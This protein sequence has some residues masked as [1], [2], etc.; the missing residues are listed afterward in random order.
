M[1]LLKVSFVFFSVIRASV[2][3]L[4]LDYV[5]SASSSHHRCFST[6]SNHHRSFS[7]SSSLHRSFSDATDPSPEPPEAKINWEEICWEA[8]HLHQLFLRCK[9]SLISLDSYHCFSVRSMIDAFVYIQIRNMAEKV[10]SFKTGGTLWFTDLT[11]ADTT[12][13]LSL[14]TAIT[15]IWWR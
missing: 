3:K 9:I 10:P 1:L 8:C 12:Y 2:P 7:A 14:L 11:T 15:F 13:I 5:F 4:L 6:S